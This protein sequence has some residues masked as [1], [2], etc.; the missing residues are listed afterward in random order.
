MKLI[1][2][3]LRLDR[4]SRTVQSDLSFT[5]G[6]GETLLLIGANG[7]GKSSLLRALAGLLTPA[8][9]IIRLEG[10]PADTTLPELCHIVGHQNG[11]KSSLTAGENLAFWASYLS[12]AAPSA[13]QVTTALARFGLDALEHIPAG[14]LSAGQKRRLGLARLLAASRPVWLLDE[15]SVSLDAASTKLLGAIISEHTASGGIAIAATHL[16]LGVPNAREIQ[17]VTP[18]ALP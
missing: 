18:E 4:G 9:G 16:P 6:A 3:N 7:A 12:P 15:P 17:L 8:G 5:A 14:Y 1:V 10:A 2:E 13:G 11:L